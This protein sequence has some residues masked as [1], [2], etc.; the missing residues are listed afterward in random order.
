MTVDEIVGWHHQVNGH[1]FKQTLGDSKGQGI[2][3][4]CSPW[5]HKELDTTEQLRNNL[6]I[7][8]YN[9]FIYLLST[10]Y[11]PKVKAL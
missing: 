2:L 9:M 6:P 8:K 1:E 11:L 5:G 3:V 4:C 10:L 7:I